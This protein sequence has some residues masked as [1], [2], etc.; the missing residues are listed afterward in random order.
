MLA[1]PASVVAAFSA[2]MVALLEAAITAGALGG[3]SYGGVNSEGK[4]EIPTYKGLT[5][6][7]M[8]Y[9]VQQIMLPNRITW[10]HE[11]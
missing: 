5:S 4:E 9:A 3:S 11:T 10:E 2:T 7:A 1:I 6:V 8:E